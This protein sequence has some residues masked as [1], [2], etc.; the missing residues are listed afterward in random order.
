MIV[1]GMTP[2]AQYNVGLITA[3]E[4]YALTGSV[5]GTDYTMDELDQA[6][7]ARAQFAREQGW[8]V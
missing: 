7:V 5:D 6:Q 8:L 1:K 2:L 4:V 3:E